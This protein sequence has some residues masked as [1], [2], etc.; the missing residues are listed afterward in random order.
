MAANGHDAGVRP[1]RPREEVVVAVVGHA[2][3]A[4]ILPG[5]QQIDPQVPRIDDARVRFVVVERRA[6]RDL[7]DA[8][9]RR[10]WRPARLDLAVAGVD[11]PDEPHLGVEP[12]ADIE[13]GP[14]RVEAVGLPRHI[15][16]AG[17][18]LARRVGREGLC[19]DARHAPRLA[20]IH[21]GVDA[22]RTVVV[23]RQPALAV[24]DD[25]AEL[26]RREQVAL[27]ADHAEVLAGG[28]A[29]ASIGLAER[30]VV[31]LD[32]HRTER[33]GA[34][35]S[36]QLAARE[37]R[38]LAPVLEPDT[39]AVEQLQQPRVGVGVATGQHR[40]DG[41][42]VERGRALGEELALLGEEQRKPR[43]V[44]DLLV[45]LDLRE[46][47]LEC[48]VGL[49]VRREADAGVEA[50]VGVGVGRC[51]GVVVTRHRR[52]DVGQQL[53]L[54]ARLHVGE[55]AE[56]AGALDAR[57]PNRRPLARERHPVRLFVLAQ[58]DPAQVQPPHRLVHASLEAQLAERDRHLDV[59]AAIVAARLHFPDRVPVVVDDPAVVDRVRVLVGTERIGAEVE[60]VPLVVEGVDDDL[61][62]VAL[63][64]ARIALEFAREYAIGR[65][66][67]CPH[68]EIERPVVVQDAE[69]GALGR[70][71]P[72]PR[73]ALDEVALGRRAR[74]HRVIEPS[75]DARPVVVRHPHGQ[76]PE[77]GGIDA[78]DVDDRVAVGR[79]RRLTTRRGRRCLR[80]GSWRD[81]QD[82]QHGRAREDLTTHGTP[83]QT[84]CD[85][86]PRI[87]H[88]RV[89]NERG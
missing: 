5:D 15:D 68:A 20:E 40:A 21:V 50:V 58:D 48:Q 73:F 41:A 35:P 36:R 32:V 45:G 56:H 2:E 18:I 23:G 1:E 61:D 66:I 31:G 80:L 54:A 67:E 70:S 88:S 42:E 14:S 47:G 52:R 57:E 55:P 65:R 63:A 19:R 10:P 4:P 76:R 84:K 22:E 24:D 64:E 74:P 9:P 37:N 62:L 16:G 79:R 83:G 53:E 46:V 78:V 26:R 82:A 29:R 13:V 71:R 11:A 87:G 81:G 27:H 77:T 25:G 7:P 44:D 89:R 39:P 30:R 75:V 3:R 60:R 59:P 69:F 8:A 51:L 17:E 72:E 85:H 33:P 49:Q 6:D 86:G 43:E 12:F 38:H 28:F 34:G